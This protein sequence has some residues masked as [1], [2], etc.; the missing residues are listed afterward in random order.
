ML[1]VNRSYR[2]F[3]TYLIYVVLR[4]TKYKNTIFKCLTKHQK[5]HWW[6]VNPLGW[7]LA[8]S[9]TN[10]MFLPGNKCPQMTS[11]TVHLWRKRENYKTVMLNKNPSPHTQPLPKHFNKTFSNTKFS[12][13]ELRW[14]ANS[15][16]GVGYLCTYATDR[17]SNTLTIPQGE[18]ESKNNNQQ[19]L[20]LCM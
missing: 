7:M 4:W 16:R 1:T 15:S 11:W 14:A 19:S 17:E 12:V 8:W 20:G 2:A 13:N 18:Q 6:W 10:L 3:I 5:V 9:I